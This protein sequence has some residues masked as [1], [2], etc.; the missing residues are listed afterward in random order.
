[1]LKHIG[2]LAH[3]TGNDDKDQVDQK[4]ESVD[5]VILVEGSEDEVHLD[6]NG[7]ERQNAAKNDV[8]PRLQIPPLL[9][10]L[11]GHLIDAHLLGCSCETG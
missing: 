7:A 10:D 2:W 11:S 8:H 1:M 5:V 9:R 6:E 3:C 4:H